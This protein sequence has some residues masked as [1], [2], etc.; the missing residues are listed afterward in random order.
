[1][2]LQ[3]A[4]G[5]ISC[6]SSEHLE[7]SQGIS[8]TTVVE[9]ALAV[10]GILV[11]GP[12]GALAKEQLRDYSAVLTEKN[13]K[14]TIHGNTEY[15]QTSLQA[16]ISDRATVGEVNAA[17][18]SVGARI[19]FSQNRN[20]CIDLEIPD[21]GGIDA[22]DDIGRRLVRSGAFD[23][24]TPESLIEIP[25]GIPEQPTETVQPDNSMDTWTFERRGA[26]RSR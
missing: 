4:I 25:G 19:I 1:M 2:S 18:R 3:F 16:V 26:R 5:T 20:P 23:S 22:L 14:T 6:R 15:Y 8:A 11:P 24:A 7:A 17:L 9:P 10:P 21:P 13:M 12:D